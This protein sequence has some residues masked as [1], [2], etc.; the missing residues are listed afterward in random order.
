MADIERV[1]NMTATLAK[2]TVGADGAVLTKTGGGAPEITM[3]RTAQRCEQLGIKTAVAMLHMAADL[4]D[5]KHGAATIFSMPEVDAIVS[6]GVPFM[7]LTLPAVD[8]IIGR[9][10]TST[11]GPP[12]DGE[13]VRGINWIKGAQSQLGSSRLRAVRY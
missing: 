2:Y 9:P 11:G 13:I 10:N 8:R 5:T 6:M 12:I 3:A 4:S 7:E 1:S